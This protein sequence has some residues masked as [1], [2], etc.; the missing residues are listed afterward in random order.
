MSD[1]QST[2]SSTT[3]LTGCVKWFNSN[4]NYGFI[5]VL[6]EGE[7]KNQDIFTHQSNIKTKHDCY[8]TLYVGECVQFELAKSDNP[9]HPVHAINISGFNGGALRCETTSTSNV[10]GRSGNSFDNGREQ[11]SR[12]YVGRGRGRGRGG[13]SRGESRGGFRRANE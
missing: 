9:K 3:V 8:R 13:E 7:N 11:T 1:K 2:K 12:D 10:N 4:I 5:T 6:T